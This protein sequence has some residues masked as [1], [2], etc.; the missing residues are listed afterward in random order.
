[1]S[2]SAAKKKMIPRWLVISLALAMFGCQTLPPLPRAAPASTAT[3]SGVCGPGLLDYPHLFHE[4]LSA[5]NAGLTWRDLS[6]GQRLVFVSAY[7]ESPPPSNL[8]AAAVRL[9]KLPSAT[10]TFV[11]IS[12]ESG[13][14]ELCV[15][16]AGEVP[17][18]VV[19]SWSQGRAWRPRGGG[20]AV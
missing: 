14:G 5:Q 7:N 13:T 8:E 12:G 16:H 1:M 10:T 2:V 3:P 20:E 9:Y 17:D 18:V 11:V 4:I 15:L 19:D 6:E